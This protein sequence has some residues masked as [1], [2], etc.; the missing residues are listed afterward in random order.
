MGASHQLSSLY[1]ADLLASFG[2]PEPFVQGDFVSGLLD[3]KGIG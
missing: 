2:E 3:A 1:W